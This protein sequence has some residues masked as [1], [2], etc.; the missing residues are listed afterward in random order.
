M[1][2]L[3]RLLDQKAA[4][5]AERREKRRKIATRE[6]TINKTC[7][8]VG[9]YRLWNRRDFGRSGKD[10]SGKE[11]E[12]EKDKTAKLKSIIRNP[13]LRYARKAAIY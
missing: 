12:E 3:G 9:E 1:Q 2:S 11:D 10:T 13:G 8:M 7:D 5:E 6:K 4:A